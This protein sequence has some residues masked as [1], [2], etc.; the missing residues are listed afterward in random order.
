[1]A[2]DEH[3]EASVPDADIQRVN[4]RRAVCRHSGQESLTVAA[5]V[6]QRPPLLGHLGLGPC[7]CVPAIH[8]EMVSA[9]AGPE[10]AVAV[11]D[12]DVIDVSADSVRPT[13]SCRS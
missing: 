8:E 5:L 6:E 12:D 7:K 11:T 13:P 9:G 4:P 10:I 1:M 3:E 2:L